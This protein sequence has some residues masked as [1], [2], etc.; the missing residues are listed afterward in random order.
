MSDKMMTIAL[1]MA[2]MSGLGFGLV[3]VCWAILSKFTAR[4][5]KP[6]K[7]SLSNS[8]MWTTVSWVIMSTLVV[9]TLPTLLGPLFF[10]LAVP[11]SILAAIGGACYDG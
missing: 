2:L 7:D 6:T 10:L 4:I 1:I 3:V 9:A 11:A 5:A 8:L